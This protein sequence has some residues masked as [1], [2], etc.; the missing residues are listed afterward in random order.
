MVRTQVFVMIMTTFFSLSSVAL[1]VKLADLHTMAKK[2]DLVIHGYVGEKVSKL[3]ELGRI[4]TLTD[5][6]VVDGL[7]GAKTGE[8]ITFYQV[9][10]QYNGTVMPIIG[11]QNF[12][13]GSQVILFGLKMRDQYVSFGAGL[14][15]LDIAHDHD[16]VVEDLGT[17]GAMENNT[18]VQPTP[19]RFPDPTMV[20]DEIKLMLQHAPKS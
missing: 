10:G 15:K 14:G 11:G 12:R 13:V 1:I 9:G 8:V 4:I 2:S 19:L 16:E 18:V 7:H 3:D 5:I 17:V 6:E 20:K